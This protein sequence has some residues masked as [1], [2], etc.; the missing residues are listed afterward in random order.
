MIKKENK[1][2][3]KASFHICMGQNK[4]FSKTNFSVA[5]EGLVTTRFIHNYFKLL[6]RNN[7][8]PESTGKNIWKK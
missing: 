7:L 1:M 3:L 8:Q 6:F 2:L 5:E 4:D